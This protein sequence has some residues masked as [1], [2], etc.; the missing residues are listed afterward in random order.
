MAFVWSLCEVLV[1]GANRLAAGHQVSELHRDSRA[2]S[3]G[4]NVDFSVGI[5]LLLLLV[6]RRSASPV[7]ASSII[8]V[9]TDIENMMNGS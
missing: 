2:F 3:L 6:T 9:S 1:C 5:I 8:V 4:C 7:T